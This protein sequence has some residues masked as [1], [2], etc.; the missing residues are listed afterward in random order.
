MAGKWGVD[1]GSGWYDWEED[2]MA[3]SQAVPTTAP[4]NA[5]EAK[6]L[7]VDHRGRPLVV[8]RPRRIGFR[9]PA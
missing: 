4:D 5:V 8:A 3:R 2:M 9:P 1:K 7:L 6:T